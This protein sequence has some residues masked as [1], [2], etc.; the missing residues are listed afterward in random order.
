M[1]ASEPPQSP[2]RGRQSGLAL[3]PEKT[4]FRRSHAL[5]LSA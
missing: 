5:N 1:R 3:L 2:A 4:R